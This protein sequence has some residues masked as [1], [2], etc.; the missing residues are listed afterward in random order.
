[1]GRS[2]RAGPTPSPRPI[3]N[4]MARFQRR[5][6][7]PARCASACAVRPAR[8][9]QRNMRQLASMETNCS[10]EDGSRP[11][12]RDDNGCLDVRG[13]R[14]RTPRAKRGATRRGGG[15]RKDAGSRGA[16]CWRLWLVGMAH[17][18]THGHRVVQLHEVW[19]TRGAR[20]PLDPPSSAITSD[21]ACSIHIAT[22]GYEE[23][24]ASRV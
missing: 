13:M 16:R 5:G 17:V 7:H 15:T 19:Q 6:S 12:R 14:E 4:S 20:A 11:K 21:A 1:M 10:D 3:H 22:N 2:L 9:L 23:D 24:T 8:C 18:A